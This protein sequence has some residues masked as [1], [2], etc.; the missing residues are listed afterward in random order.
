MKPGYKNNY[1]SPKFEFEL[2]MLTERVADTC[3]G[4]AYAWC[5]VNG[6]GI[7]E[8]TEKVKLSDIG[9]GANGCQGY[10]IDKL[11]EYFTAMGAD[12]TMD[13]VNTNTKS[14]AIFGSFS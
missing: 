7:I 9:L 1:E 11:Y 14:N 8:G 13:D 3:W 12:I 10:G 4:Y 2:L 5:D 6:N